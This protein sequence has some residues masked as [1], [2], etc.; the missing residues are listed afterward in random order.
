MIRYVWPLATLAIWAVYVQQQMTLDRMIAEVAASD[1][2][3]RVLT[4]RQQRFEQ[5]VLDDIAHVVET[6]QFAD[7]PRDG[8]LAVI[9]SNCPWSATALASLH[10]QGQT[11]PVVIASPFES[12]QVVQDWLTDLG[13]RFPVVNDGTAYA[14]GGALPTGMTPLFVEF[15]TG[16]PVTLHVGQP[17]ERWLS[18]VK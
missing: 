14:V 8:L 2:E 1:G 18:Q 3:I 10:T 7:I 6:A 4:E 12:A 17:L 9:D 13:V 15:R 11:M 16:S 5:H